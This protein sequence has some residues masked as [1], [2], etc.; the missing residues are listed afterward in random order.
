MIKL[1]YVKKISFVPNKKWEYWNEVAQSGTVSSL[2]FSVGMTTSI[3]L[4]IEENGYTPIEITVRQLFPFCWCRDVLIKELVSLYDN[5][6]RPQNKNERLVLLVQD[7]SFLG[8]Q[9]SILKANL[10]S[11]KN[12]LNVNKIRVISPNALFDLPKI[13]IPNDR[14][15]GYMEI[16]P[17]YFDYPMVISFIANLL[18]VFAFNHKVRKDYPQFLQTL[19]DLGFHDS[20]ILGMA[21]EQPHAAEIISTIAKGTIPVEEYMNVGEKYH[22]PYEMVRHV[23]YHIRTQHKGYIPKNKNFYIKYFSELLH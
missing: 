8:Y 21:L 18:R 11:I 6:T 4:P 10:V 7:R 23:L 20:H 22:G 1:N 14:F 17:S 12:Y 16:T 19:T 15:V 13:S 3:E 5:S 2:S 9:T